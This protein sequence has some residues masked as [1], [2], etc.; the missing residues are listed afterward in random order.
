MS[1]RCGATPVCRK[2]STHRLR[3]NPTPANSF[4]QHSTFADQR[5]FV[6]DKCVTH[7]PRLICYPCP[8]P[9]ISGT[10]LRDFQLYYLAIYMFDSH[11]QSFSDWASMRLSLSEALG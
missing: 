5:V 7:V 2:W 1:E 9:F 8:R 10:L 6:P 4:W 11:L 3:A